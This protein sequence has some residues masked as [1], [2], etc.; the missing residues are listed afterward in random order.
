MTTNTQLSQ[1]AQSVLQYLREYVGYEG[2]QDRSF[3]SKKL[4]FSY[5]STVAALGELQTAGLV[6]SWI[7][8]RRTMFSPVKW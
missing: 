4:R 8:E 2:G 1:R 3:L 7:C 6:R 5:K